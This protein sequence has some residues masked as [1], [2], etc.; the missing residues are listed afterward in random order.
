MK[1]I[2]LSI[3]VFFILITSVNGQNI[4][5]YI[6]K[7]G[8]VA[9]YPFNGN[10]ND[11]SG[12]GNNGSISSST[13]TNDRFGNINKAY[14]F[15]DANSIFINTTLFPKVTNDFS[16][17]I[18]ANFK[19]ISS[20]YTNTIG[21]WGKFLFHTWD[22]GSAYCGIGMSADEGIGR[23]YLPPNTFKTNQWYNI[24]F[25]YKQGIAKIYLDNVLIKSFNNMS[26]STTPWNGLFINDNN[27]KKVIYDDICVYN[28]ELTAKDIEGIYNGTEPNSLTN[29]DTEKVGQTISG[30]STNGKVDNI[31]SSYVT[32]N[33][34][35]RSY[36]ASIVTKSI[37]ECKDFDG[38]TYKSVKIGNQI[39]MTEDLRTTH[40]RNG[41]SISQYTNTNIG[42]EHDTSGHWC[43]LSMSSNNIM[44]Y[45]WF[46]VNNNK[47]LAPTG[48]HIPSMLEWQVLFDYLG[49]SA[50]K[51]MKTTNGWGIATVGGYY[52]N[53]TCPNCVNWN[54]QYRRKV[55]CNV[56]KDT[57]RVRGEYIKKSVVNLNGTNSSGFNGA[58]NGYMNY[59]SG[60]ISLGKYSTEWWSSTECQDFGTD[61]SYGF[62]NAYSASL[63]PMI[64]IN[65]NDR[66][67]S[68]LP[69][70]CIKD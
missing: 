45:D 36:S 47:E 28:R 55:P 11:E 59:N 19:V 24:V 34:S 5:S 37:N 39:W 7:N 20:T 18:W 67:E 44:C 30:N 23:F 6:P 15:S 8:L 65:K 60:E 64:N 40:F 3:L 25:T 42:Y 61:N 57:R 41:E 51:K 1:K 26:Q 9:W 14:F 52:K 17:S 33:N 53:I 58:P 21:A 50:E 69:I 35:Q 43:Y 12:N 49:E 31:E 10:A 46:A 27:Q 66:K 2:T 13:L 56:C 38:N 4:P 16:I 22:N 48:W 63:S 29:S 68:L 54:S 62:C 32:N 70:R